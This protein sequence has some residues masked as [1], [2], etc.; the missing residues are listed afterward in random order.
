MKSF[1]WPKHSLLIF[2]VVATWIKTFIVYTTSFDLTIDNGMQWFILFMNPLSFLLFIYGLSLFMKSRK[3]RHAY[4]MTVSFI[5]SAI[6]YGNVAFYRFYD[7]F[8]TLPVLMQTSNFGDL[9]TSAGAIISLWDVLFFVDFVALFFIAHFIKKQQEQFVVRKDVRRAYFVMSAAVLFLNLGL[10]EIERPQLLTRAFDRELLVKN[11]G[12]YNYH[13]YDIYVQSK[14]SAQRALADGS[15]LTEISNYLHANQPEINAEMFGKYEGRN[16]IV[17]SMESLQNFVI[18]REMDGHVITPFLNS[19]TTDKDTYYFSD[20]YHQTG[21]GKTSD[22]E[23]IFENS[24]YGVGGGSVF[25]TRG[26]N[27]YN[28]LSERLGENEYFTSVLHPNGKTFWNRDMMYQSLKIENFFDIDSYDVNDENS[29][30]WGL[31]DKPFFEQSSKLMAGIDQPFYS[32]LITLTNHHPFI[33]DEEDIS[34]P[35]YTSNSNTLNKYFQTVRYMDEALEQFFQNLKDEGLYENSVIVMYGDHYGISELHNRSM[36]MYLEKE[37]ITPFDSVE[38]QQVPLFIHI[39]GSNDGQVIDEAAGQLDLR[40]TILHLLGVDT[41]K[42]LQFGSDLFAE[43]HDN[44]IT[45]RDGRFVTDDF[46][47]TAEVCYDRATGEPLEDQSVCLPYIE[48]GELELSYSDK[49]INGDLLRFYDNQT[50]T[51]LNKALEEDSE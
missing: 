15:E 39:P 27:T 50:G 45:F 44:L 40:P 30:S 18:N 38:L 2:A 34:I 11:I 12:T 32:R 23:F 10:S 25:F 13:L 16:L 20:F 24:M 4:I 7:D 22:S 17:V 28:S 46:I 41:S 35:E 3:A 36:A 21:L 33:L 5:L 37:E 29:V 48:K 1:K 42:D 19:L 49:I 47:Y 43:D 51:I 31:K 26:G 8:V 6:L 9:G 14:S